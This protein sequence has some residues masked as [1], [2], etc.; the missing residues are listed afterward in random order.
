MHVVLTKLS[1]ERHRFEVVH[2]GGGRECI[3]LE[4]RGYLLHD[5]LHYALESAAERGDG[6][7][8]R[9]A[10]GEA[11][12]SLNQAAKAAAALDMQTRAGSPLASI[13]RLVGALTRFAKGELDVEQTLSGLD[14]AFAASETLRPSWVDAP[15]LDQV[16]QR[17]RQLT[18]HWRALRYGE[19]LQL[20]W[21]VDPET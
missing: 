2:T 14:R 6:F 19:S 9:L 7:F 8:A 5:L 3:E 10:R 15:L 20:A 11:L 4:T 1:D 21:P 16:Q 12:S 18:G 17:L 13:E